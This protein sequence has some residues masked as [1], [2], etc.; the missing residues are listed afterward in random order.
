[1]VQSEEGKRRNRVRM[2]DRS[3]GVQGRSR[4]KGRKNNT[5]VCTLVPGA[6]CFGITDDD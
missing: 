5:S 1:M 4:K 3:K 6:T 2:R